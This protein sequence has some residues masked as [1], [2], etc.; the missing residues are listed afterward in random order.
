MSRWMRGFGREV[1]HAY[2]SDGSFVAICGGATPS[3]YLVAADV[4]DR[5]CE[6]SCDDCADDC[7]AAGHDG[8][9]CKGGCSECTCGRHEA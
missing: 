9:V 1:A 6:G 4:G 7:P 8:R 5:R 3:P 2:D